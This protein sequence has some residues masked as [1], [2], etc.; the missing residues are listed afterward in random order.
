[1]DLAA[2]Y[3]ASMELDQK[4]R[5]TFEVTELLIQVSLGV[6][7][8]QPYYLVIDNDVLNAL[9]KPDEYRERYVALMLLFDYIR[10]SELD[11]RSAITPVIFI[12]FSEKD[13]LTTADAFNIAM[14][15]LHQTVAKTGLQLFCQGLS[16]F[17]EAKRSEKSINHDLHEISSA[18]S[19][20]K[21]NE[22]KIDL[23]RPNNRIML[24]HAAARYLAPKFKP[25]YF[26][27]GHT[28]L[29]IQAAIESKILH[30]KK[31]DAY[32]RKN[33]HNKYAIR[34]SKLLT[35][36]SGRLK[37][38]GDLSIL[39]LCDIGSQFSQKF[40]ATSIGLTF[41]ERLRD[42][43]ASHSDLTVTSDILIS[44]EETPKSI[45]KKMFSFLRES[46]GV[47]RVNAVTT[48]FATGIADF[49]KSVEWF[50]HKPD[51][52]STHERKEA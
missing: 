34:T 43:L 44:G 11:F 50:T 51:I 39:S 29:F 1:M 38:M 16:N 2:Q 35:L 20:I 24:P 37:G 31:N 33:F 13:A 14:K 7:L 40:S 41:D 22:Y 48:T 46:Q 17:K 3:F 12:E 5:V 42:V 6:G 15:H 18:L 47:E 52:S 4:N 25:K 36:Q 28:E 27:R 26:S 49:L 19:K 32:V 10:R 23:S 45:R 21:L 30:N 9:Q 8:P